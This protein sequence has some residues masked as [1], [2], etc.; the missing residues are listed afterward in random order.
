VI[1]RKPSAEAGWEDLTEQGSCR[2]P[3]AGT[4]RRAG[5]G[6]APS[7]R[8]WGVAEQPGASLPDQREAIGWDVRTDATTS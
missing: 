4:A 8:R 7:Y 5:T 2:W 6:G 3:R 1:N